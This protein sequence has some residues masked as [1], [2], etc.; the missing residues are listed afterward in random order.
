MK[1]PA[2]SLAQILVMGTLGV[3]MTACGA[4]QQGGPPDATPVQIAAARTGSLEDT[5]EYV[6]NLNNRQSVTLRPRV[7]GQ[8]VAL[9]AL[10]GDAV[11]MGTPLLQIDPSTQKATLESNLASAQA[12]QADVAAFRAALAAS[13]AALNTA[14]ANLS[15]T[16]ASRLARA[17]ELELQRR[18]LERD[19]TLAEQGVI[20]TREL[21]SRVNAF[22]SATANLNTL[23]RQIEAQTAAVTQGEAEVARAQ[24]NL[25]ATEQRQAQAQAAA[26][27]EAAQL[28]FF[29]VVA[30]FDGVIGSI[31]VKVGD[32]VN[33]DTP[34]L[35]LTQNQSFELE[36]AVPL[37]KA[38]QLRVG[39]PV[40]VLDREGK[41]Q[42]EGTIAFVA[43]D[44]NA[45]N[46]SILVK[47]GLED[48][49]NV[50]RAN[51]FLR[52]QVV[53][54]QREGVLVPNTAIVPV[55]GQNFV[56]AAIAATD[57]P[58]GQTRPG[59]AW[60]QE[61]PLIARQK[62]VKI[63]Q[64]VGNDREILEGLQPGDQ[65]VVG[66]L[67]TLRDGSKIVPAPAP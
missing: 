8:I 30:P 20:P 12:A 54:A 63:G 61:K 46:Q 19:R 5:S 42:A 33:T 11:T 66:G 56:F 18:N 40:R 9:N 6:A 21:E 38:P 1:A 3:W 39:L 41:P 15:A 32:A 48:P 4:A 26:G 14:R 44:V 16:Q 34:L 59:A 10:Q 65:I 55:A 7:A 29:R 45:R 25:V 60:A 28:E 57:S 67:Q 22:E 62:P 47:V 23:D 50:L 49:N 35:T 58:Q 43:P 27:R 51:Q 13:E 37:E 53:W 24:A 36:I 2:P 17:S 52:A 31:P 64:L